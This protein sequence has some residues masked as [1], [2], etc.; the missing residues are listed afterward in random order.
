ME[1]LSSCYFCGDAL[2]ASLEEYPLVP[3]SLAPTGGD[4]RTVVLCQ[5]C[6]RKLDPVVEVVASAVASA[7]VSPARPETDDD[8]IVAES[9]DVPDDDHDHDAEST[10]NSVIGETPTAGDAA[11][12]ETRFDGETGDSQFDSDADDRHDGGDSRPSSESESESDIGSTLGDDEDVLRPVGGDSTDEPDAGTSSPKGTGNPSREDAGNSS[13]EDAGNSS[14]REAGNSSGGEEPRQR[15]YT[16]GTRAG[17]RPTGQSQ[18]GNGGE[19]SAGDE[20]GDEGSAGDENDGTG[21][22][23]DRDLTLSRLENTNVMRL[24]QNREFPVERDDF[25]IVASSAYEV[26]P[27]HCE[28]VIDLAVKHDLLREE[29]GDL[30]AGANWS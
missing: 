6:K 22:E 30:H 24:L 4:R 17:G 7:D 16:S 20:N 21:G 27:R 8:V 15:T 29:D 23:S 2:D 9:E 26:S 13:R 25:V 18:G 12:D 14:Q 10:S 1:Q 28:K 3:D 19:G 11:T 5:P